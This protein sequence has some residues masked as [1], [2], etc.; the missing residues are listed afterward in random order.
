MRDAGSIKAWVLAFV[1][2]SGLGFGA[3][4]GIGCAIGANACPFG[5]TAKETSTDGREIFLRNCAV[6]HGPQGEGDRGPS[7]V[8]GRAAGYTLAELEAKISRGRPFAGMPRYKGELT[9][10]QIRAV[11][12]AVVALREAS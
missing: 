2:A 4:I 3:L 8:S 9:E 7:L 5:E 10:Q 12:E 6:C 11:A 1:L